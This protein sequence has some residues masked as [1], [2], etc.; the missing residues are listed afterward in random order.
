[1]I[2]VTMLRLSKIIDVQQAVTIYTTITSFCVE[3]DQSEPDS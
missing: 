3:K 1:M 2:K